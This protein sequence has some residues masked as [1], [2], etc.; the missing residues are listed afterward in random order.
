ML[1]LLKNLDCYSPKHIGKNDILICNNKIYK[2]QPEIPYNNLIENVYDCTGHYAFPGIID[3]HVHITGG[4][5]EDGFTSHIT[6]INLNDIINAGVTTLVGLLGA[7][8]CT[9]SLESL[10]AKAKSLEAQ[11]IST[12]IYSGSYSVPPITFTENIVKDM[13]LVDKVIGIGEIA[14]SDHRSSH[15]DSNQLLKIASDVHLGGLLS[16]K[17]GVMHLHLGDGKSGLSPL[18]E[19]LK[20][21]DLPI[22]QFVPTHLN[23]NNSLFEQAIDYLKSGG[24]IDLTSG[25]TKGLSVPDAIHQLIHRGVDLSRVTVSSDSNGSIPDGGIS[26]IQTLYDDIIQCITN[27]S[28]NP[29][30]AFSFVTSNVSK[31]L[32]LYPQKGTLLDGSDADI[33]IIDSNYK[34]KKLFCLGKLLIHNK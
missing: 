5:G 19:M 6:E 26:S 14:I 15:S 16:S 33:L 23:R 20:K 27:K 24:N 13:V 34:I 25:E 7:D 9:R 30:V 10:Y 4:G 21:C 28:L 8:S 11:G 3:Q 2:V 12:Y 31:L 29:E 17:A 22:E 18:I 32:K 1:T